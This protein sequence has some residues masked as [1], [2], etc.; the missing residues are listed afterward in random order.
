MRARPQSHRPDSSDCPLQTACRSRRC[1]RN[2]PRRPRVVPA[3]PWP[4]TGGGSVSSA[5]RRF[6]GAPAVCSGASTSRRATAPRF[7]IAHEESQAPCGSRSI[8]TRC[9]RLLSSLRES[10]INSA[11]PE[12]GEHDP[13]LP[14]LTP[15][16][17][18]F[19]R[20]PRCWC[21]INRS[22]MT[23]LHLGCN[24]QSG[25]RPAVRRNRN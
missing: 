5:D 1:V 3:R 22:L 23:S 25:L 21:A 24:G 19:S 15:R 2:I 12:S 13:K 16:A 11:R 10:A 18:H 17:D 7:N 20:Y 9:A 4:R 14:L 8:R 6:S